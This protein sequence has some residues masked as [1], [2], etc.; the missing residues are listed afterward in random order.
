MRNPILE[1]RIIPVAR[2]TEN[3]M[4]VLSKIVAAATPRLAAA[5]LS[6]DPNTSAARDMLEKL[7]MIE[8]N[9]EG[10]FVTDEGNEVMVNQNLSTPDG[11]LTDTGLQS[12][13]GEEAKDAAEPE[14]EFGD[15]DMG[16]DFDEPEGGEFDLDDEDDIESGKEIDLDVEAEK[17]IHEPREGFALLNDLSNNALMENYLGDVPPDLLNKLSQEERLQLA[18]VL[19]GRGDLMGTGE[20]YTKLYNY[21]VGEMPYGTAKA[22]TGDPD[23]WIINRLTGGHAPGLDDDQDRYER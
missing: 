23:E 5:E 19:D 21:F 1:K 14:D 3:Q 2:P 15:L 18:R 9:D 16:M 10:A 6:G 20:L 22:R 4:A 12:A 7:G 8:L 13:H 11:R 17:Q